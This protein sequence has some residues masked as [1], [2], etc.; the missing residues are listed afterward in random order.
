[1]HALA[2][3]LHRASVAVQESLA[4]V[5]HRAQESFSGI[6]VVRGYGLADHEEHAFERVSRTNRK[7]QVRMASAR[8][9]M[10]SAVNLA[11]EMAFLPVLLVGGWA[12][13]DRSID[14]GD[15][16]KF[17]DLGFKVFWPVIALGWIAGLYPRAVASAERI[18]AILDEEVDIDDPREPTPLDEVRGDLSLRDVSYTYEGA[19]EPAIR[20][21]TLDVPAGTS[22]GVVGPTGCGKSTLLGLLGRTY[23]ANGEIRLDRVPVRDLALETLRGAIAYVPRTA[24][25][26][27]TPI[28]TTSTSAPTSPWTT[29][30][31]LGASSWPA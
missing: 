16:F 23:D 14:V 29:T 17:I 1:M 19:P 30:S 4:D 7:H 11:Y 10:H 13:I 18:D 2:P 28:A 31:S 6:R 22:L 9:L 20:G 26:S 27:R 15:L 12:M 3:R 24:S 25:S 5:S 8:G 21:V